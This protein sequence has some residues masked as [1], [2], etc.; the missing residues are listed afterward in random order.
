[1][2]APAIG[3]CFAWTAPT[4]FNTESIVATVIEADLHA[5]PTPQAASQRGV[6]KP[7]QRSPLPLLCKSI[8]QDG[9]VACGPCPGK[10][11]R[12][13]EFLGRGH[14]SPSFVYRCSVLPEGRDVVIKMLTD[15]N[16]KLPAGTYVPQEVYARQR[17]WQK[18]SLGV[19][20]AMDM[21]NEADRFKALQALQGTY[22]P[23]SYGF[24]EVGTRQNIFR[25]HC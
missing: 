7:D 11:L 9:S 5:R 12:L 15:Q 6:H 13:E 10:T 1:M 14:E 24:Y 2:Q 25:P 20:S 3:T 18:P 8:N 16:D 4:F 19:T 23:F 17:D 22:V 21:S